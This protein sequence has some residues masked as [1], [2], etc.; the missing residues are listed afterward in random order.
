VFS[1]VASVTGNVPVILME[2][3]TVGN[4]EKL[5]DSARHKK[6]LFSPCEY[7]RV[8]ALHHGGHINV[9]EDQDP[10]AHLTFDQIM[11]LIGSPSRTDWWAQTESLV[12]RLTCT[13]ACAKYC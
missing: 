7:S 9:Y 10:P 5:I 4:L 12:V 1:F 11:F 3:V 6:I 8:D 2:L 13:S